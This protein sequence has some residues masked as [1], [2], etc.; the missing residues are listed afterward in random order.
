MRSSS[1]T[2][3]EVFCKGFAEAATRDV[4]WKKLFCPSETRRGLTLKSSHKRPFRIRK[5]VKQLNVSMNPGNIYSFKATN[6]KTRKKRGICSTS[7]TKTPERY[8]WRRSVFL[9]LNLNIFYTFPSNSIT[10]F[11]KVSVSWERGIHLTVECLKLQSGSA[12]W[13]NLWL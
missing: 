4:L 3:F 11:E 10:D 1:I 13:I 5:Y 7:T 2:P 12:S 6:S 9:L 8:Q